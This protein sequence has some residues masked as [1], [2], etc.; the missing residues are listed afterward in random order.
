[1]FNEIRISLVR[2]E[3]TLFFRFQQKI[4]KERNTKHYIRVLFS[5]QKYI[6]L[7]MYPKKKHGLKS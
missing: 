3:T 2:V 1:M 6:M 4:V 5:I 7:E